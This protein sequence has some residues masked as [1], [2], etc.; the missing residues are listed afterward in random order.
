MPILL[1]S[2]E[3][4]ARQGWTVDFEDEYFMLGDNS[5]QSM[6]SRLWWTVGPHLKPR[7]GA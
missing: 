6:D 2:R 1:R 7:G 3:F 5:P 4:A